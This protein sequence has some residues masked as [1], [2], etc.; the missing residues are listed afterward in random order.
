MTIK[1]V[2]CEKIGINK[3]SKFKTKF[4]QN[5]KKVEMVDLQYIICIIV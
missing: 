3:L 2:A 4:R 5:E 1:V